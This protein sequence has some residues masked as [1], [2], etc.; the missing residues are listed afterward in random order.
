MGHEQCVVFFEPAAL[1]WG[2]RGKQPVI[3]HVV[4]DGPTSSDGEL[5]VGRIVDPQQWINESDAVTCRLNLPAEGA[6]GKGSNDAREPLV[7]AEH[8]NARVHLLGSVPPHIA[9]GSV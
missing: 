8:P 2:E 6:I 4:E 7:G 3:G 1:A 5:S 9:T